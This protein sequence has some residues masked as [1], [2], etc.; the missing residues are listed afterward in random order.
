MEAELGLD[1]AGPDDVSALRRMIGSDTNLR[2]IQL[3]PVRQQDS[4]QM[5]TGFEV[6]QA[7]LGPGGTGVAFAGVLVAWL[8][9]RRKHIK[10]RITTNNGSAELDAQ[11]INDPAAE[12]ERIARVIGS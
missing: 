11:G 12:V 10:L 3:V 8:R 6:L 4:G 1:G 5:G 7:M 2:G 9:S